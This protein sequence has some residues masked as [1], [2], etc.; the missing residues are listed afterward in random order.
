MIKPLIKIQKIQGKTSCYWYSF[1]HLTIELL[2]S[3]LI[4]TLINRKFYAM[5]STSTTIHSIPLKH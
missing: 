1:Q 2:A 4:K 3:N 5:N